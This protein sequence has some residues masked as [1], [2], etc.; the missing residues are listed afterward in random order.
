MLIRNTKGCAIH[1]NRKG[2]LASW[3]NVRAENNPVKELR[4]LN[5]CKKNAGTSC[6]LSTVLIY[7]ILIYT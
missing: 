3:K 6:Y 4:R 2:L 7:I 5:I 1:R